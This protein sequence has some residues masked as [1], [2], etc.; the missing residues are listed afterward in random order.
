MKV[1]KRLGEML[2]DTGVIDQAKLEAALAHQRKWGGKLGQALVDLRMT[3]EAQIVIALSR[4]FGFEIVNVAALQRSPELEAALRLV[5][6]DV[7]QR[8]TAL[9]IAADAGSL[10]VAMSDPSNLAAADELS[11]RTGRRIKIALAGD[12]AIAAAV[13]RFYFVDD[14]RRGVLAPAPAGPAAT[15][16]APRSAAR[17]PLV[18]GEAA[19]REPPL[20]PRQAAVLDGLHR[21]LRGDDAAMV[22]PGELA[23]AVTRVLLRKGVLT[24]A[25]LLDEL[26][27]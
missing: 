2:L 13:K 20:T 5:P 25:E 4:K 23:A 11:F 27:R 7:A 12:R 10:T 6:P 9:P 18:A 1:R 17:P 26:M 21:A 15:G 22:K 14:D 8:L 19:P 24:E 16:G 3:T